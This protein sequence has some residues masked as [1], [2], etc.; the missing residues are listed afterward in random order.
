MIRRH[1]IGERA[2]T[3]H[4]RRSLLRWHRRAAAPGGQEHDDDRREHH[5][6][7]TGVLRGDR[8]PSMHHDRLA[9]KTRRRAGHTRES[10]TRLRVHVH[11]PLALSGIVDVLGSDAG[12]NAAVLNTADRSPILVACAML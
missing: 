10:A 1:L 4:I 12:P 6:A 2:D 8:A 3:P 9:S 5:D 11:R 7:T